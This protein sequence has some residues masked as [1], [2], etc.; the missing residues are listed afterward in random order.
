MRIVFVLLTG[1]VLL[2]ADWDRERA[3]HYLD[4]RQRQWAEWKPA[5][6][7]GGPCVSCHTGL[8]YLF[9]RRA[10]A[11]KNRHE[12]EDLL[13]GGATAR[14]TMTPPKS[15]FPDPGP[16][17]ILSLLTISLRRRAAAEPLD[18]SDRAALENLWRNQL[19]SGAWTWFVNGL[20]PVDTEKSNF[21]GAALAELALSVYPN[22]E[23]AKRDAL[24]Q[25]IRRETPGQPL[26]NKLAWIAFDA[27]REPRIRKAVL[28]ELWAAQ[29]PDGGWTTPALGP[30][31]PHPDAPSD[32][33]SNAYA[34]AWAAFTARQAG[35][36][37]GDK[38]MQRALQ[39]LRSHQDLATG[40]WNSVSMN[41]AYEPNS[42][43]LGFMTDA[44]TGFA[45]AALAS[46][47]L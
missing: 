29:S 4:A 30:W 22:Q 47:P 40:A 9:A 13:I 11:S 6:R 28:G 36:A 12:L 5:Q 32:K 43:Q 34:T 21:F 17:S 31:G 19:P 26:H 1:T 10:V 38:R 3:F 46:C 25:F 42:I 2:A 23:H 24:R 27:R 20:D 35:V 8:P 44:A 45:V 39:W 33:G 16:E 14:I 37:C 18:S 15:M 7:V 41:Q